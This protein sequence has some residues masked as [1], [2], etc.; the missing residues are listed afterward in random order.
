[1]ARN[2]HHGVLLNV[3]V[4]FFCHLSILLYKDKDLLSEHHKSLHKQ[5]NQFTSIMHILSE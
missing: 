3:Y 5:H 4:N 1:M 2:L